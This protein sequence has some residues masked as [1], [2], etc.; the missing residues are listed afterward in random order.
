MSCPMP[1]TVGTQPVSVSILYRQCRLQAWRGE[2]IE[3]QILSTLLGEVIG[4]WRVCLSVFLVPL[5]LGIG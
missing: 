3:G 1:H 2:G 4:N 5:S